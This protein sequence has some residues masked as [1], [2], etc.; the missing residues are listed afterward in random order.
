MSLNN[1]A[2]TMPEI[3]RDVRIMARQKKSFDY[4]RKIIG[5]PADKMQ[6][7]CISN[8]IDVVGMPR[9]AGKAPP[10]K[11]VVPMPARRYA[12]SDLNEQRHVTIAFTT[13]AAI[14]AIM[15]IQAARRNLSKSNLAHKLLAA[16]EARGWWDDILRDPVPGS[17][18]P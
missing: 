14:A 7:F 2:Q 13:T 8:G 5:W 6:E 1:I 10:P 15:E 4:I 16:I 18:P 9:Q 17:P 11:P 12:R 3:L